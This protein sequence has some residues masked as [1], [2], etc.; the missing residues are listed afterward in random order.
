MRH[1]LREYSSYGLAT[2]LLEKKSRIVIDNL[3]SVERSRE[4][5]RSKD[6]RKV[7]EI[8]AQLYNKLETILFLLQYSQPN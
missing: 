1:S 5:E 2:S 3:K 6:K 8:K 7:Q 4:D